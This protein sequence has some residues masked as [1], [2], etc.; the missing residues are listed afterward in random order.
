M[1][2]FKTLASDM[3]NVIGGYFFKYGEGSCQHSIIS[4]TCLNHKYGDMFCEY[5]N[6][7]YTL[8]SKL[9]DANKKERVYLFPMGDKNDIYAV[10]NAV[11]NILDDAHENDSIVKFE[12]LT[13]N[14][15]DLILN[16]FPG[17]FIAVH[18]RD[19]DEYIC[20]F[21]R[22]T[23]MQGS[24]LAVKRNKI[25]SFYKN[26]NDRFSISLIKP[27]HIEKIRTF[28]NNWLAEKFSRDYDYHQIM[29]LKNENEGIQTALDNFFE[30]GLSGVVAFIDN[31][32]AAYAYGAP[33]NNNFFDAIVGKGD[34]KFLNIHRALNLAF[35]KN[36]CVG[37]DYINYEEDLGVQGLRTRKIEDRPDFLIKKYI[38]TEVRA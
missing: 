5:N 4:A 1:L 10:K 23:N 38:L 32:I 3:R 20:S 21:D 22:Q 15:A 2:A 12:T 11:E 26:Y 9:C 19:K 14:S 24:D 13:K 18:D 36:C 27:E 7:L 30:I 8:R 25:R 17:K 33:L 37:Y 31:E 6:F 34:R 28:Q 29:Q 35:V 16:L